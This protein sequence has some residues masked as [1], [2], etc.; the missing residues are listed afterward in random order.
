MRRVRI[1]S[2]EKPISPGYGAGKLGHPPLVAGSVAVLRL[3]GGRYG[4]DGVFNGPLQHLQTMPQPFFCFLLLCDV[5]QY[6]QNLDRP[7]FRI[8]NETHCGIGPD[9]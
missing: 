2:L 6:P 4:L 9:R 7:T 8:P 5:A 3:D 1:R